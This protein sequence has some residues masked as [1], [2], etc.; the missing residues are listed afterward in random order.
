MTLIHQFLIGPCPANGQ[1]NRTSGTLTILDPYRS[2]PDIRECSWTI[3]VP[4]G[5]HVLLTFEVGGSDTCHQ[6]TGMYVC[7]YLE[8]RQGSTDN[9]TLIGRYCGKLRPSPVFSSV[10][11]MWIKVTTNSQQSHR[12]FI[13]TYDTV[14]PVEGK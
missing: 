6:C 13:A 8:A 7:D 14:L 4:R 1:L 2:Y 3:T 10:N 9:S 12:A 5:F 11:Q